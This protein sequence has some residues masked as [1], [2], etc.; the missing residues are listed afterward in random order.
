MRKSVIASVAVLAAAG[1]VLSAC[2]GNGGGGGT[3]TTGGTETSAPEDGDGDGGSAEDVT[4]SFTWWG[5]DDR[6]NRYEEAIDLFETEYPNIT[7]QTSW[8]AFPDYWTA[9]NTEAAGSALPDVMQFDSAYLREY[10]GNN[11]LLDLQEWIDGGTIDLSGFDESLVAAGNLDSVQVAIPTSTNTLA[12]F[13]NPTVIEQSGVEFPADG[14]T[15]EDL[16]DFIQATYDANVSTADGYRI[17]GMGN[18]VGTFWFFL[19][20]QVQQGN[21]PFTEDGQL[22]FTQEDIVEF[23]ELTKELRANGATYPIER[24]VALAPLGGFT[25][26]E[27]SAEM[28]WSNFLAGYTNDSGVDDIEMV[29]IPSGPNGTGNFFRPSMHLASGANTQHP[30]EAALLINFLLTNEEVGTIFG[31]SKGVPADAAQRAAVDAEEGS[32]DAR[33]LA[34]EEAVAQTET[35]TAPIPVKGFGSIEE[36]WRQLA[37]E[38]GYGSISEQDFASQW[39]TEAEMAV[40]G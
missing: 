24:G 21:A 4:I 1:M 27:V 9:R 13:V 25:V 36:T 15:Y 34:Y 7:V 12:M 11:R 28:S 37:E 18:Y 3:E 35:T 6:A 8:Q 31:T 30:E 38:L 29:A 22:N 10:A 2:S 14:Y 16:N 40:A 32:V 23:L 26:N 5:N 17:Y 19:Q 33:V 39:W 20:Y